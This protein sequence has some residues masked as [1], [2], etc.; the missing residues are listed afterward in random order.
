[1]FKVGKNGP[2]LYEKTINWLVLYASTQFK[3]GSDVVMCLQSKEYIG[4]EAPV[5]PKMATENDKC[6]WDYKMNDLSKIEQKLQ[7]KLWNLFMVLMALCY[8]E[9]KNQVKALSNFKEMDK[10]LDSMMLMKSIKKMIYMGAVT[11]Y[12][13]NITRQWPTSTLW[14]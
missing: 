6:V 7:G 2:D 9:V 14:G 3:N 10:K 11:I 5:M 12:M 8:T 4:P 1:M 13:L